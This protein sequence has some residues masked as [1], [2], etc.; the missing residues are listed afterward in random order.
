MQIRRRCFGSLAAD[1]GEGL[2]VGE[3]G[4]TDPA[5]VA[6]GELCEGLFAIELRTRERIRL[7]DGVPE[8]LVIQ[9]AVHGDAADLARRLQLA[10][11]ERDRGGD[12]FL[13][14][15]FAEASGGAA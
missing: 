1:A 6:L 8:P 12:A 11:R 10:Q 14:A 5:E 2:E 15:L 9:A 7:P 3:A 13:L 4:R